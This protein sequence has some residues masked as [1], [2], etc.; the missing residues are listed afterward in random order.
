MLYKHS[1]KLSMSTFIFSLAQSCLALVSSPG[2]K[3]SSKSHHD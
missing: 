1:V 3:R 2:E